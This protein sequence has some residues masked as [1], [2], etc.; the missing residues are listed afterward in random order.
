[1]KAKQMITLLVLAMFSGMCW[2][3]GPASAMPAEAANKGQMF[4]LKDVKMARSGEQW[5]KVT[6]DINCHSQYPPLHK[7]MTRVLFGK[8]KECSSLDSAMQRHMAEYDEVVSPTGFDRPVAQFEE[9]KVAFRGGDEKRFLNYQV[10]YMQ[11]TMQDKESVQKNRE[12]SMVYDVVHGKMLTLQDVFIPSVATRMKNETKKLPIHINMNGQSILIACKDNGE[13][14]E[15][16]LVYHE[17]PEI[18]TDKFKELVDWSQVE[19]RHQTLVLGYHTDDPIA[20]DG[21]PYYDAPKVEQAPAFID[22]EEAMKK[23]F[24]DKKN[25]LYTAIADNSNVRGMATCSFIVEADGTVTHA[26]VDKSVN[27]ALDPEIAKAIASM[28]KWTPGMHEGQAVRVK[29]TLYVEINLNNKK[30]NV[31]LT[32]PAPRWGFGFG[33]F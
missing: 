18:F 9:I 23:W 6:T 1:M 31:S 30:V 21:G 16:N 13:W 5:F 7:M 20:K 26:K 17:N 10:S 29:C 28:P 32:Q 3:Q 2:A 8:E 19:R 11:L 22:G 25:P 33:P 4:Q 14:K 12:R 24:A 27:P 15:N